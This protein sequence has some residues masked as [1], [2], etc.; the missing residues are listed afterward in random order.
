MSLQSLTIRARLLWLTFG[1]VVPLS[2]IGFFNLWEFRQANLAQLNDSVERQARLAATAFD[3]RIT[4]ERRTL[5]TIA[6]LANNYESGIALAEYLNSIVK[7]RPNWFDV[8][9]VGADG[10]ILLAQSY[11]NINL[12]PID[13]AAL[14]REAAEKKS[15]VIVAEQSEDAKLR[16]LTLALPVAGGGCV[17]ARIDGAGASDVF[18]RLNLPPENIVAVFDADDRLIYRSR[19]SP[20]QMSLDVAQTPLL[21]A[22][23][24]KREGVV[25][26]ESP[27]DSIRR[28][29]GLARIESARATVAIGVPSRT[30]YEAARRSFFYQLFFSLFVTAL[31]I[32]AAFFITLGIVNPLRRLTAAARR[33]GA[34]DLTT[35]AEI[36]GA[37]TLRELGETFNRM[38]QEIAQREEDLKTLDRLKSEFVSSVSHELRTPL[39]TIKTLTRVLQRDRISDVERREFLA[40]IAVECDRQ[41]D[42][43]QTLLDLS[44]IETGAYKIS[45][46]PTDAAE[47]LREAVEAH[48]KNA[49]IRR[50]KLRLNLPP[51]NLPPAQTDAGALRQ[52]VS[53]L[54]ENALKYTAE[55]G[56]IIVKAFEKNERLEIEIGDSGCGIQPED[57]PH[58]F[59][60]FYRGRPLDARDSQIAAEFS[61]NEEEFPAVNETAGIGLGLFLVHN[62]VGQIGG[63]IAAESPV[64]GKK[65]GTKLTVSLPIFK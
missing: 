65:I 31:A 46:K 36:E 48:R 51:A 33:L 53:S 28:V 16:L 62:L 23:R 42:F 63:E 26:V 39:T 30:L 22:L 50:L 14:R 47:I 52:I 17:V 18:E 38:A 60:K 64:E 32:A 19:V 3:E 29:Y 54:I 5:E 41:I 13:A 59:K 45:L 12:P 20:E 44:R 49:E 24:D 6:I 11:K 40:T 25:E 4:A 21:A 56:E 34:G 2:L 27:Y 15:L 35:R 37:A 43:V 55:N 57:L 1:L 61:P 9:L 8:R 10:G 58:I 7:T